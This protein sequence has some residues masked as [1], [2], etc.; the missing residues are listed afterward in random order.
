MMS[1]YLFLMLMLVVISACSDEKHPVD[2]DHVWQDQTDMI[3]KARDVEQLVG[4]AALKQR[5]DVEQATQ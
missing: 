5:Q 3:D 1:R 4:D 2:G